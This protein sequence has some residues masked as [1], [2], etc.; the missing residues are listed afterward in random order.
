MRFRRVKIKEGV[1]YIG[2]INSW[3]IDADKRFFRIFV[4]LDDIEESEFMHC[5]P[6]SEVIPSR[7]ADFCEKFCILDANGNV[8]FD[9]LI[10]ACVEVKLNIGRDSNFYVGE[11]YP[12]YS[13]EEIFGDE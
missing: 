4:S 2:K 12:V 8:E 5:I 9:E 11:I 6:Y 10:E 1:T 13:E 7:L 3:R